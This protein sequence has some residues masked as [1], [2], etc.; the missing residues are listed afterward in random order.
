MIFD[1]SMTD[2]RTT[3][4]SVILMSHV[5]LIVALIVESVRRWGHG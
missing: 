1:L 3:V 5:A 4:G 2:G